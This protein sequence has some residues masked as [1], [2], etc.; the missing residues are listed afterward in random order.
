MKVIFSII[1]FLVYY[2]VYKAV[3]FEVAAIGIGV[4]IIAELIHKK[5]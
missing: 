2:A 5:K 4:Q 1:A 3:G